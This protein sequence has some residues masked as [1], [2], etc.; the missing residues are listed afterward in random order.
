MLLFKCARKC[1]RSDE[2]VKATGAI[3]LCTLLLL[4]FAWR[5]QPT[6]SYDL[7]AQ[8]DLVCWAGDLNVNG[9]GV[10][11]PFHKPFHG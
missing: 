6:E 5:V 4:I 9:T 1:A 7:L 10:S 3:N 11:K 8:R 2:R